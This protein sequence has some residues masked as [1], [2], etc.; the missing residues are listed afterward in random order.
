MKKYSNL[1]TNTSLI[2]VVVLAAI[3]LFGLSTVFAAT[4]S[5]LVS[6][7]V[8]VSA[9]AEAIQIINHEAQLDA[10]ANQRL[11]DIQTQIQRVNDSLNQLKQTR[12]TELAHQQSQYQAITQKI[13]KKQATVNHLESTLA[14]LQQNIQTEEAR[15]NDQMNSLATQREQDE[16]DL[17]RQLESTQLELDDLQTQTVVPPEFAPGTPHDFQRDNGSDPADFFSGDSGTDT[18]NDNSGDSSHN[19]SESESEDSH[20]D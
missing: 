8:N 5:E 17:R 2:F 16:D 11:N 15:Y 4:G 3:G 20:D 14:D 7:P 1:L 18:H 12:E 19:D 13:A 10:T 9:T 6:S